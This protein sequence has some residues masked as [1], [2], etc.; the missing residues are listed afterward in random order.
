MTDNLL[1]RV[2]LESLRNS[3]AQVGALREAITSSGAAVE[4]LRS[5]MAGEAADEAPDAAPDDVTVPSADLTLDQRL[6]YVETP[7][8][9]L[10]RLLER[11]RPVDAAN[12]R[13]YDLSADRVK[14]AL[15]ELRRVQDIITAVQD[16]A[17]ALEVEVREWRLL[18]SRGQ[19]HATGGSSSFEAARRE[20]D[21][22]LSTLD[23]GGQVEQAWSQYRQLLTERTPPLFKGYVDIASGL[24]LRGRRL[25]ERVCAMADDLISDWAP[26]NDLSRKALTIP[27]LDDDEE[28]TSHTVRLG[29]AGWTVWSLPLFAGTF[30]RI[31]TDA[32]LADRLT[33]IAPD[34]EEARHRLRTYVGDSLAVEMMGP[35]YACALI[36]LRLDP[37]QSVGDGRATGYDT[38]RAHVVLETMR[39]AAT[40]ER[41]RLRDIFDLLVDAWGEVEPHPGGPADPQEREL[42]DRAIALARQELDTFNPD[43]VRSGT[44]QAPV[45]E[46]RWG[47][48]RVLAGRAL[49]RPPAGIADAQDREEL[50]SMLVSTSVVDVLNAA[51]RRRLLPGTC[52]PP[53]PVPAQ[54]SARRADEAKRIAAR[55]SNL[56]WPS[57]PP[58]TGRGSELSRNRQRK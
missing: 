18:G 38:V 27:G 36:L 11:R 2:R 9:N 4:R 14:E 24:T 19:E 54:Q 20:V 21:T 25:E 1:L 40:A 10:F 33:Q 48:T 50:R 28:Q 3:F 7:L 47:A 35:A 49:S 29:F 37:A 45:D 8:R 51:W 44:R 15:D 57:L 56:V 17:E 53:P 22:A 31:Y 58:I 34:D 23:T 41:S 26:Y 12:L 6:V 42:A 43:N 13:N 52:D 32:V 46:A 5:L 55:V 30:W 39:P 16:Q